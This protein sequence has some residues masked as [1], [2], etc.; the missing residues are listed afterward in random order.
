MNL[1]YLFDKASSAMT[2][3]SFATFLAIVWWAY[4]RRNAGNFAEAAQLPFADEEADHG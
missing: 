2:L 1:A 3:V 4:S